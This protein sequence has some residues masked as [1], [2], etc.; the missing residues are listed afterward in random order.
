MKS[1]QNEDW[2]KQSGYIKI[3]YNIL[4]LFL[5]IILIIYVRKI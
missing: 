1:L 2:R 3:I 4:I 5:I